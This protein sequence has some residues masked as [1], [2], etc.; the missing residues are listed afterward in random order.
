[1]VKHKKLRL[2]I[3]IIIEKNNKEHCSVYSIRMRS[4]VKV[5]IGKV[6]YYRKNYAINNGNSMPEFYKLVKENIDNISFIET[7]KEIVYMNN[8]V[9]H[10]YDGPALKFKGDL[11]YRFYI[12]GKFYFK[13][14]YYENEERKNYLI[15]RKRRNILTSLING[16]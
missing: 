11:E 9:L 5:I 1:M 10:N 3:P 2:Y 14:H 8:G 7:E 13:F 16:E 4:L 15:R 6:S 12:K